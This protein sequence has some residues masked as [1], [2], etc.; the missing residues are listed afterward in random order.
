MMTQ[1]PNSTSI[2]PQGFNMRGLLVSIGLNVAVPLLLYSLSKRY[3]SQSEVVALSISSIFP[4]ITSIYGI[5]RHRQLDI[6]ATVFLLGVIAGLLGTLVDG[7][8][9][10]LLI[11]ESF[12]TGAFGLVCFVSLLFRRPLMYY[13]GMQMMADND[14]VKK[15]RFAR[16]AE[17]P[18]GLFVHRLIT[19][20]WG[21]AF[22]GEFVIR[23]VLVYTLSTVAVLAISPILLGGIT[24]AT[25]IWTFAYVRYATRKGQEMKRRQ[26]ES[27]SV[28]RIS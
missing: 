25:F 18:Y 6:I 2:T 19:T 11:R 21:C 14:P 23:V 5:I 7:N 4:L 27:T 9:K 8:V 17:Y 26:L 22:V 13:V 10:I 12:F 16:Q 20:V 15:A 1:T 24:I 28:D 3:I